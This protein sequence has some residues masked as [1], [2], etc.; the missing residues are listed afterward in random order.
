MNLTDESRSGSPTVEEGAAVDFE[1]TRMKATRRERARDL[2]LVLLVVAGLATVFALARWLD[3]RRP[4]EDPFATYEETY[5]RPETARRLSL[6]FNGLAADWYWL[7]SLQYVGRK[8]EAYKGD[9]TL[10][11]MSPLGIRHLDALLEQATSLDPQFMAA[12]EFGAVVLPS[13]DRDAAVRLVEKGIR[14]NPREWR[15]Y[16]H[17]GYIHWQAGRFR[18]ASEAYAAG[19]R[20][21][22][23]PDWMNVMAAQM[24]VQGGSRAVAREIYQRMYQEATDEQVRALATRRLAQINSL[25][26]RETIRGALADFRARTSRCPASWREVAPM[27]RAAR[28]RI[29][30]AGLPL[31]PS[32]VP[33]VLDTDACDVKLG[34]RSLIP[35]K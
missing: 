12:Y 33:Y 19:A 14:E 20:V 13:I 24:N 16:Q 6:A 25:E 34:E 28:L 5:V 29:D 10:D 15:L 8:V 27:L 35:K 2:T 23:A 3:A 9:F 4:A 18:E 22:G 17:L 32:D 21:E 30:A 1:E 7:R 26:E 31:D 11:D